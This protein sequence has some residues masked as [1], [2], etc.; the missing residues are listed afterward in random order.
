M[1]CTVRRASPANAGPLARLN[2][3]FNG[4]HMPLQ[5]FR[6]SLS[7][8]AGEAVFLAQTDH[9][10]IGYA[11]ALRLVSVCCRH[12]WVEVTEI[13][14]HAGY[15][16]QGVAAALMRAVEKHAQRRGAAQ[17]VVMHFQRG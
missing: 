8:T 16:G 5:L 3:E 7:R 12:P 15:R 4:M 11:C 9:E 10:A 6:Q 17:I 1:S 13:Y 14:V 2:S